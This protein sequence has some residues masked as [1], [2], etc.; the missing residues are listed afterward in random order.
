MHNLIKSPALYEILKSPM[1]EQLESND[2]RATTE[3]TTELN[4]NA[5]EFVPRATLSESESEPKTTEQRLNL[6]ELQRQFEAL[7]QC[8]ATQPKLLLPWKGFP[9][10]LRPE[11]LNKAPAGATAKQQQ[12]KAKAAHVACKQKKPPAHTNKEPD[13]KAT[14]KLKTTA[15]KKLAEEKRREHERKI[16]LEALKLVEQ[17]RSRET[18]EPK[19]KPL[20][21]LSRSPVRFTPEERV[22]VDRLRL[23]K[24]EH[25]ER[26]LREMRDEL[27]AK[28]QQQ[29]QQPISNRYVALQRALKQQP[30]SETEAATE[31]VLKP[32]AAA[33]AEAAA[34]PPKR[35]IPTVKQWDERCKAKASKAAANKENEKQQQHQPRAAAE[36]SSE[37]PA[38][39]MLA[40]SLRQNLP[41]QPAQQ[42]NAKSREL[43]VPR[44]WPR[45]PSL[46]S[47]E[48]RRGNLTHARNISRAFPMC[49]LL[50]TPSP[51]GQPDDDDDEDDD[52]AYE[53]SKS[54]KRYSIEQ[55]LKLEPQPQQLQKP[56]IEHSLLK[57]NFLF[58]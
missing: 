18:E 56:Q 21:H 13:C 29:Q 50:P 43:F 51:H 20:V 53:C 57:L 47:S 32:A 40:S 15:E 8:K 30:A 45:A 46:A 55:L 16:A 14:D 37:Q 42:L 19:P 36:E 23:I 44:F 17:R 35:Y 31:P 41:P 6:N 9:K 38:R 48:R 33:A 11:R 58:D 54:I 12:P 25:I 26:V 10:P 2:K 5:F 49:G 27:E 7:D 22:R 24:R 28:Q 1:P 34:A 4:A 52:V 3:T 39:A